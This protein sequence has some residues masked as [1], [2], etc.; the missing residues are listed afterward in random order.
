VMSESPGLRG[1][2]RAV[3]GDTLTD[4]VAVRL[5]LS[6]DSAA[7]NEA[8]RSASVGSHVPLA[9][10]VAS[11]LRKL[12][13]YRGTA[14]LRTRISAAERAWYQPGRLA[15]EWAFCTA[16][17]ETYP[18]P[19]QGTDFLIWSMTA[20]RTNLLD[21]GTPDRVLFLP[22]TRFKVLRCD[23]EGDRP[24]VLLRE[25]SA[26]EVGEDGRVE[27]Q[28]VPL[29][30]IAMESL[31]RSMASLKLDGSAVSSKTSGPVASP[32]GLIVAPT[33]GRPAADPSRSN[34][35]AMP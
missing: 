13:S 11:G 18:A 23:E 21:P 26:S 16:R 28:R 2:S 30:E 32:P 15:T 3:T 27:V 7:V 9:R 10:C 33:G 17:T 34:E 19:A 1:T 24:T 5:Y 8:V 12:P 25:L 35:G 31:E 4:L 14:L 22:G 6:G 20:R 29:D